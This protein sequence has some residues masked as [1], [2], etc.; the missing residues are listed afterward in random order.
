MIYAQD[1][2]NKLQHFLETMHNVLC[3]NVAQGLLKT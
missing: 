3:P 2:M 1:I